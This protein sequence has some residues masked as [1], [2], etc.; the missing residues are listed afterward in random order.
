MLTCMNSNHQ[1]E[2]VREQR[3]NLPRRVFL[4][5]Q[6]QRISEPIITTLEGVS[7]PTMG[8]LGPTRKAPTK[9]TAAVHSRNSR[10][11][12]R[13]RATLYNA[14]LLDPYLLLISSHS[15][16]SLQ[17]ITMSSGPP[18]NTS[19]YVQQASL[20]RSN[21]DSTT[22]LGI[23]RASISEYERT[24]DIFAKIST[25]PGVT[26]EDKSHAEEQAARAKRDFEE[27]RRTHYEVY[28]TCH[29]A[30]IEGVSQQEHTD[31]A[32]TRRPHEDVS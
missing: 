2:K 4:A 18:P 5:G 13:A 23:I 26:E 15:T 29:Q 1:K 6:V 30:K 3:S 27:A 21:R 10:K 24:R 9:K 12:T 11:Q 25:Q 14:L 28:K 32:S 17:Y 16:Y 20:E 19:E 8:Q 31:E 22:P 7:R